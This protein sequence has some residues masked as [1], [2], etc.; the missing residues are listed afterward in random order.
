MLVFLVGFGILVDGLLAEMRRGPNRLDATP[1]SETALSGPIPVKKA[2]LSDFYVQGDSP[3]GQVALVLDDFFASYWF[4]SGMWRGRLVVGDNPGLGEYP[5]TISFK[6]A[7][8]RSAQQ[9]RVMIWPDAAALRAGSE[10]WVMSKLNWNPFGLAAIVIPCALVL[11][12][13]NF[14]LGRQWVR[15]LTAQGCG[16]VFK[17]IRPTNSPVMEV[18]FGMGAKNGIVMGQHCYFYL[19]NG[20]YADHGTVILVEPSYAAVN[21]PRNTTVTS[22]HVAYPISPS[23]QAP[24]ATPVQTL[25]P[26]CAPNFGQNVAQGPF[27]AAPRPA[28]P[29][30]QAAAQ[31]LAPTVAQAD[32]PT[33]MQSAQQSSVAPPSPK[34]PMEKSV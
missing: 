25:A 23:C 14:L 18:S 19:P 21:L 5:F 11:S 7:P 8:P 17:T 10:S 1:N 32:V 15:T 20:N 4:G 22:G 6:D 12:L 30:P 29:R 31:T 34:S 28:I 27:R 9:Y 24:V 13:I 3:D 2:E 33:A 26:T 16:E